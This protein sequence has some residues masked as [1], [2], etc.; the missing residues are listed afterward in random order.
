MKL[1]KHWS[2]DQPYYAG[3]MLEDQGRYTWII[4]RLDSLVHIITGTEIRGDG[5]RLQISGHFQTQ[6]RYPTTEAWYDLYARAVA[7]PVSFLMELAL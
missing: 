7:D 6:Q 5:P 1:I 4:F 3:I 2:H